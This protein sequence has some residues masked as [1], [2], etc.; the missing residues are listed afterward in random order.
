VK[1]HVLYYLIIYCSYVID[2]NH[3]ARAF[4]KDDSRFILLMSTYNNVNL[5]RLKNTKST[6]QTDFVVGTFFSLENATDGNLKYFALKS[7]QISKD[8]FSFILA[9]I[10]CIYFCNFVQSS[11]SVLFGT[12]VVNDKSLRFLFRS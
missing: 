9:R 7:Y 8:T 6:K 5:K 12:A 10:Q 1:I 4:C 3:G 11:T 2:L